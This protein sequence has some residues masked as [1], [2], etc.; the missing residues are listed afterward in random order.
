M[1]YVP[2]L[3]LSMLA[4]SCGKK[5]DTV[6]TPAAAVE[7]PK[8]NAD[9]AYAFVQRQVDFGPRV[10]NTQ[11]HKKAA[12]YLEA[13]LRSYGAKVFVQSFKATTVDGTIADLTN[14]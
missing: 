14:I 5:S 6:S 4:F 1:K 9:S 13:K 12:A 11:P 2:I 8:F 10:P 7:V 3:I